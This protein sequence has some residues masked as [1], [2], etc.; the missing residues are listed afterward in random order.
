MVGHPYYPAPEG[1]RQKIAHV[2]DVCRSQFLLEGRNRFLRYRQRAGRPFCETPGAERIPP[3][4]REIR[5]RHAH[6]E[7]PHPLD[8]GVSSCSCSFSVCIAASAAIAAPA[9]ST[10]VLT[11]RLVGDKRS[12]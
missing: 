4:C 9:K 11:F 5:R 2:S 1:G 7:I 12:T 10:I 3:R 6:I 8:I